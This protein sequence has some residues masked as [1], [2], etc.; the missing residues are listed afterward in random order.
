MASIINTCTNIICGILFIVFLI[1]WA[2]WTKPLDVTRYIAPQLAKLE[3]N[4]EF[5]IGQA[6]LSWEK[7]TRSPLLIA[8]DIS[9]ASKALS[10][11]TLHLELAPNELL[12]GSVVP[13]KI[14]IFGPKLV[15]KRLDST[16]FDVGFN[17]EQDTT[18]PSDSDKLPYLE[19]V[20]NLLKPGGTLSSLKEIEIASAD[21][22]YNDLVAN[23]TFTTTNAK[24]TAANADYAVTAKL[25]MHAIL[26]G[27]QKTRITLDGALPNG[28]NKLWLSA[29]IADLPASAA[30]V[31]GIQLPN[32]M[33][34]ARNYVVFDTTG[35]LQQ[36]RGYI[37]VYNFDIEP[38]GSLNASLN[39]RFNSG[40]QSLS[41]TDFSA[42]SQNIEVKGDAFVQLDPS[43]SI[44]T[45][46]INLSH[47]HASD[48]IFVKPLTLQSTTASIFIDAD[49][50]IYGI[51]DIQG[52]S[53]SLKAI[54]H[55][56]FKS[57]PKATQ[58]TVKLAQLSPTELPH[59]WPKE[60]GQEAI[61]WVNENITAG[62]FQNVNLNLIDDRIKL[63]FDIKDVTL[64]PMEGMQPL[65]VKSGNATLTENNF[66]LSVKNGFLAK[67]IN[68]QGTQFIIPDLNKDHA[69][70]TLKASAKLGEI[71]NFLR[72]EPLSLLQ[73]N[74]FQD[75][76]ETSGSVKVD[77]DLYI[78]FDKDDTTDI[79]KTVKATI[80][81][82]KIIQDSLTISSPQLDLQ[83]NAAD[84]TLVGQVTP[85]KLPQMNMRVAYNLNQETPKITLTK[86]FTQSELQ[87][88]GLTDFIQSGEVSSSINILANDPVE[89]SG[90]FDLK[91]THVSLGALGWEKPSGIASTLSFNIENFDSDNPFINLKIAAQEN[92][93]GSGRLSLDRDFNP[94]GLTM[95]LNTSPKTD[96]EVNVASFNQPYSI[97]VTGKQLSL[98]H[99]IESE[100]LGESED[101]SDSPAFDLSFNIACVW[102]SN[103]VCLNDATGRFSQSDSSAL[104]GQLDGKFTNT[105]V[106]SLKLEKSGSFE[107]KSQNA[108]LLLK[109]L[110][111]SENTRR[112]EFHGSGVYNHAEKT[113]SGDIIIN[114]LVVTKAP[115]LA[116]LLSVASVVGAV[117]A[118]A[119]GGITFNE[120]KI[121]FKK[122]KSV[123]SIKDAYATGASLGISSNGNYDLVSDIL[124]LNGAISPLYLINGA[125]S[126]I[127]VIG[128]VLSG[129]KGEGI[130]AATYKISG[131]TKEPKVS[132]NPLSL[133]TL[134][135]IRN[136][137]R[138]WPR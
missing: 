126:D 106:T 109:A 44:A 36:S 45:G 73:N 28:S 128:N 68:V 100:D 102:L 52:A 11:P 14:R 116:Q 16:T 88:F 61:E 60:T 137:L 113:L 99:M 21:I 22:S 9:F 96:V 39:Y 135:I 114:N 130:F 56:G 6:F 129:D 27:D 72:A 43:F 98:A 3:T 48:A 49:K 94:S 7:T 120:V 35:Q 119:T 121:P 92:S 101:G 29:N 67:N 122:S 63:D 47:L 125:I 15:I 51:D 18:Q 70:L 133:L 8:K 75:I 108:G 110:D 65:L 76:K 30:R 112:G 25:E 66:R 86:A 24:I 54:L 46:T 138:G 79:I 77:A 41:V 71:L 59:L 89:I 40:N 26:E 74:F 2:I 117:D 32:G 127:P 124:N 93:I 62:L 33:I 1:L 53:S 69:N 111:I 78:P 80:D 123:I 31:F 95:S 50:N 107:V 19:T 87:S 57:T 10:V 131:N 5:E 83:I 12:K 55:G 84:L 132:V 82:P 103:N 37:E 97:N 42:N 104:Q 81:N 64:I 23:K 34:N 4:I 85:N 90:Q 115:V 91:N 13:R 118:L 134:G 58:A 38:L 105:F 20:L 17:F 136:I